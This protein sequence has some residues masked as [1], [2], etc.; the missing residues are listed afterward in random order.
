MDDRRISQASSATPAEPEELPRHISAGRYHSTSV[1]PSLKPEGGRAYDTRGQLFDAAVDGRR[2]V[3]RSTTPFC[4]AAEL[5]SPTVSTRP[6]SWS[7]A[8]TARPT[9]P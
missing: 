2:I 7:C 3:E 9:M 8:M 5:C 4:A 6:P 1:S